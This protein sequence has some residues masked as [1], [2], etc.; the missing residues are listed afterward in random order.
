MRR[1]RL[2]DSVSN[3]SLISNGFHSETALSA[4]RAQVS[5]IALQGGE[6]YDNG[7]DEL[8]EFLAMEAGRIAMQETIMQFLVKFLRI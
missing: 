4:R 6:F 5:R 1:Y 8:N 7:F 3:S 2:Q